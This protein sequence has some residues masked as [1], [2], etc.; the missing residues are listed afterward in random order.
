MKGLYRRIFL[1]LLVIPTIA[2]SGCRGLE[3][4]PEGT[5]EKIMAGEPVL[6]SLYAKYMIWCG[7]DALIY[8][9]HKASYERYVPTE[10]YWYDLHTGRKVLV[11]KDTGDIYIA[12]MACAP[13]GRWLV[14]MN[15]KSLRWAKSGVK[16]I[17]DIWRYEVSTGKHEKIAIAR[18][19]ATFNEGILSPDGKKLFLGEKPLEGV[20]M[21]EPKWEI[22]WSELDEIS[23]ALW[24]RDSSAVIT[25][26]WGRRDS[27]IDM[28]IE[29]IRPQR[30]TVVIN[31]EDLNDFGPFYSDK[32]GR[33]YMYFWDTYEKRHVVRCNVNA[34]GTGLS[35]K[36]VFV[37]GVR[38]AN[39]LE[40]FSDGKRIAFTEDGGNCVKAIRAEG[41]RAYCI[42]PPIDTLGNYRISAGESIKIS[43]DDRWLAFDLVRQDEAGEGI[44]IDLYIIE[45]NKD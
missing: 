15:K 30:K 23:G 22:V 17:S 32:E 39:D 9:Y 6:V 44:G 16:V 1:A 31:P 27:N 18:D 41:K 21:P 34:E 37:E 42:T 8:L 10:V 40:V 26:Y 7:P 43:P 45:I 36:D 5:G 3:K 38:K 19:V 12:P 35:C 4:H 11:G 14:Y 29:V 2:L 28:V 13:D 20:E 33:I 25:S 24:F